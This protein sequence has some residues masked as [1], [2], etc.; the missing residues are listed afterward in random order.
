VKGQLFVLPWFT[1]A[2]LSGPGNQSISLKLNSQV[3]M[4]KALIPVNEI[5]DEIDKEDPW[6][7]KEFNISGTGEGLVWYPTSIA[8][9]ELKAT[10]TSLNQCIHADLFELFSFKTKGTSHQM[11]GKAKT[12]NATPNKTNNPNNLKSSQ[13]S[14]SSAAAAAAAAAAASLLKIQTAGTPLEFA[15][16]FCTPARFNQGPPIP[17]IPNYFVKSDS[18]ELFRLGR[19]L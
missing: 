16:M 18:E 7:K 9:K 3:E 19:N 14:A 10:P 11:V 4:T 2:R 6:V 15:Q 8:G 1:D 13:S 12:Q 5:V 17:K